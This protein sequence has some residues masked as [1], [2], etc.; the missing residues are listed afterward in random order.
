MRASIG[1]SVLLAFGFSSVAAAR[2][3][4]IVVDPDGGPGQALLQAAI[5]S[6]VDGDVIVIKAGQYNSL[7]TPIT[8]AGKAVTI[9]ADTD[10]MQQVRGAIVSRVPAGRTV[11]LE[12][13]YLG[14]PD[15]IPAP[16]F[17]SGLI[18]DL[19]GGGD[20]RVQ[21]S[22][23]TGS[24]G[25]LDVPTATDFPVYPAAA[26]SGGGTATFLNCRMLGGDGHHHQLDVVLEHHW[27]QPGAPALVADGSRVALYSCPL[28]GGNG[29]SGPDAGSDPL[30]DG[31]SAVVMRNGAFVLAYGST[32][33][34][35]AE[36]GN[37]EPGC[38]SGDGVR[39]EASGGELWVRGT[40]LVPGTVQAPGTSGQPV[41]LLGGS[42]T[43]FT[44][45][46]QFFAD[47]GAPVYHEGENMLFFA[48]G[49]P[50]DAVVM[51]V[52]VQ[53][54]C[55][56]L[57]K[58]QG[59]LGLAPTLL[60]GP[61]PLGVTGALGSVQLPAIAPHL[62]AAFDSLLVLAQTLELTPSGPTLGP[63]RSILL[64]DAAIP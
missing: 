14:E 50:G 53:S 52:S 49:H 13:L 41:G 19:A 12:N 7:G 32:Y 34:G 11:V 23:V 60:I 61:I 38:T 20:L 55:A 39:V 54:G 24:N 58:L 3:G 36:G 17:T 62:P 63:S 42:S 37:P 15:G 51:F 5:D 40:T 28:F 46:A 29:G 30:P 1:L 31:A 43:T 45:P 56:P 47:G 26:I 22:W 6:A 25:Y 2:A 27:P 4:V 8:I 9:A 35:G 64:L 21:D 57:S 16:G 10:F 33:T 18:A 59:V 44:E 48:L